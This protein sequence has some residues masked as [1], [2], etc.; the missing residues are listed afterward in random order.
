[1]PVA[2]RYVELELSLVPLLELLFE[3]DEFPDLS[4]QT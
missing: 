1:V 4:G 2:H 3:S